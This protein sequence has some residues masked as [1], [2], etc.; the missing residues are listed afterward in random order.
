MFQ[1][2]KQSVVSEITE[3]KS[4]FICHVYH[5]ETVEEA[6]E[7]L[8]NLR[9]KYHDARHNCY[10]YKIIKDGVMRSSD[11]GEPSGTAGVPILNILNGRNLSNILVV[12]TRYFGGILLGTGG[13]VRAYSSATADA[14]ECANILFQELGLEAK[15][16]VE[17][18]DLEE[19]KYHVKNRNISI[20]D[21]NYGEKIEIIV[22]GTKDDVEKLMNE[23]I[24]DRI[25]LQDFEIIGEKYIYFDE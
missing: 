13:L 3:K 19:L 8:R 4:K 7:I 2:I 16:F 20:V 1:T 18:K 22:E 24:S 17:Y 25:I 14:L 15:F 23:K 11:D 12:V 21:V 6:E 9:K 5:V 10:A